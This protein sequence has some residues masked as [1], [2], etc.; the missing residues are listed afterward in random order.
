V[1]R[2]IE[3]G[4]VT[5]FVSGFAFGNLPVAAAIRSAELFASDVIPAL[6]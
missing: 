4:R 1:A 3:V 6:T 2:E 5:Y